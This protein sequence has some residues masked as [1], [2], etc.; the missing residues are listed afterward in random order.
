MMHAPNRRRP[1]PGKYHKELIDFITVSQRTDAQYNEQALTI[2][3]IT[4]QINAFMATTTKTLYE[5]CN[6]LRTLVQEEGVSE[7]SSS[8]ISESLSK[9]IADIECLSSEQ[10][11]V[12]D[13]M[14][15]STVLDDAR[16]KITDLASIDVIQEI[17]KNFLKHARESL[18]LITKY[19]RIWE[20]VYSLQWIVDFFYVV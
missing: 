11:T 12:K 17:Q 20:L 16:T 19:P 8:A 14:I 2:V 13:R 9:C 10:S 15:V 18:D 4:R 6:G 3:R 1:P 5:T 7:H